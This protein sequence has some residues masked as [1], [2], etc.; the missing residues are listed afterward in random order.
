M[1][2]IDTNRLQAQRRL[3][4]CPIALAVA[5]VLAL[6]LVTMVGAK[7]Q[8]VLDG[9][10]R[11]SKSCPATP[12]IRSD[13]NP[14]G[15]VLTPGR[16]YRLL[17]ENKADGS[18]YLLVT[19]GASP[20]K[21]W[22]EKTCGERVAFEA[23]PDASP[24]GRPEMAASPS[25]SPA[26]GDRRRRG[27]RVIVAMNW[28]PA[29]CEI[30]NRAECRSQTSE[31]FDASHFALHG[32]WPQPRGREFCG[33]SS[34]LRSAD[35]NGDWLDLPAPVV[36]PTTRRDL[37]RAMPG[38]RSGLDRHEW[39]RHGTCYGTDAEEYFRDSLWVLDA[40][41][42]SGVRT[43][44][45]TSVGRTL[46]RDAVRAAFDRSFGAGTG[47]RVRLT[48]RRDGDRTLISEITLG[49][50][51]DIRVGADLAALIRAAPE[52]RGGCSEGIVDAVGRQ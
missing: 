39:L 47:E 7:A 19:P 42:A 13:D 44:F 36:S 33:V 49:L 10:L 31:R 26:S 15:V 46:T 21:R 28:Q 48:C 11:A 12:A 17:A 18:H 20:E 37:E 34:A 50:S 38:T 29:F 51:G 16:T 35:E 14:G 8:P 9:F 40:V 30:S 41:N 43:L 24:K 22:V 32:L 5:A 3:D 1:F 52:A 6:L 2:L 25:A 27:S 23:A 45:T 4:V